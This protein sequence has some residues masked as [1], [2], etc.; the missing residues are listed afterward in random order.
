MVPYYTAGINYSIGEKA[1]GMEQAEA[2]LKTGNPY[3]KSELQQLVGHGY[4]E[5]G[6]YAKAQPYLEQYVKSADKVKKEDLYEL[7]YC[8]YISQQ[9]AKSIEAFKPLAGGDDSLSQHAMYLLGDAYLKTGQKK[10]CPQCVFV[11]QQQQQQ[12]AV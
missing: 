3:Y 6:E 8:Y 1:K 5:K 2:A 7:A 12:C 9:Y 4:F 10:Q 11:L